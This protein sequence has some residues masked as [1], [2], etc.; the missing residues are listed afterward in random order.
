MLTGTGSGTFT[1]HNIMFNVRK[2]PV[3]IYLISLVILFDTER[4][5]SAVCG[6]NLLPT[7]ANSYCQKGNKNCSYLPKH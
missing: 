2:Y 3:F 7:V 1:A 4:Q 6:T 5:C